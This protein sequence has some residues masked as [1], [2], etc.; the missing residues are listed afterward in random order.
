MVFL[1]GGPTLAGSFVGQRLVDRVVNYIAPAM[2]GAGKSGLGDAGVASMSGILRLELLHV[3]RVG[4]D[5]RLV[6]RPDRGQR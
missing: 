1:E 2:L 6:A 5:V 3:G 4:T